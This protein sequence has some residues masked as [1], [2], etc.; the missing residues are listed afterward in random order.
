MLLSTPHPKGRHDKLL[1][2]G[3]HVA[4]L[5]VFFRPAVIFKDF[6]ILSNP[7]YMI[8]IKII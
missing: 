5:V 4:Q 2:R 8:K 3:P 6:K 7:Q 1:A